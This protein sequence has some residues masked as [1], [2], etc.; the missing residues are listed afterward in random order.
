[1]GEVPD[2]RPYVARAGVAVVPLQIAR[3]IQNK[4]LEALAMA[5][6]TVA[7]PQTLRGL[8]ARPGVHLLEASSP[9]DW[10]ENILRLFNDPDLGQRLGLAG[11]RFV[12][13]QH[14]WET[15]LEPFASFL[16]VRSRADLHPAPAP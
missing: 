12:E 5:K 3:G 11:R 9:P 8:K 2:V 4:T 6:P 13:E 7:S 15:C 10:V 16:T 1:V 14:H